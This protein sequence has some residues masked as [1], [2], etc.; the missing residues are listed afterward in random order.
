MSKVIMSEA[1]SKITQVSQ[2]IKTINAGI[3]KSQSDKSSEP[4]L[5]LAQEADIVRRPVMPGD[6]QGSG[7][8]IDAVVLGKDR[9]ENLVR[10]DFPPD[11][12]MP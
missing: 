12:E 3:L 1:T 6:D 9:I 11:T 7:F 10:S 4:D 8:G 2:L 5:Q